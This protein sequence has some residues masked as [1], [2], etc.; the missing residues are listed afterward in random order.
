M[1]SLGTLTFTKSVMLTIRQRDFH[2]KI[3][4]MPMVECA[5][6]YSYPDD[7][8]LELFRHVYGSLS[9]WHDDVF[10]YLCMEPETLWE[11]V[12]GHDYRDNDAF[13]AAMKA[14]YFDK[15]SRLAPLSPTA[16]PIAS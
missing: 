3:L 4:Q 10:F 16:M 8:K 5:G 2:S 14:A 1:V 11:P 15:I 6:K 9:R 12:F 7:I 13:E